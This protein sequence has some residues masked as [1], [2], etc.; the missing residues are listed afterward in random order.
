LETTPR[1]VLEHVHDAAQ[2]VHGIAHRACN[3][4]T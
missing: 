4:R 1:V 2:I 3:V